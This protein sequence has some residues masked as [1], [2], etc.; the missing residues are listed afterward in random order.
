M[1]DDAAIIVE[2]FD[3]LTKSYKG[4]PSRKNYFEYGRD[5][6]GLDENGQLKE[7]SEIQRLAHLISC[8][9][10]PIDKAVNMGT[11]SVRNKAMIKAMVTEDTD[12][13]EKEMSKFKEWAH[14]QIA[15]TQYVFFDCIFEDEHVIQPASQGNQKRGFMDTFATHYPELKH[16]A[17]MKK[18]F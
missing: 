1:F 17:E 13:Y 18:I 5:I 9:L 4:E 11:I 16:F 15:N 8:E 7:M 14:K 2:A 12:A 3:I 10:K 6:I